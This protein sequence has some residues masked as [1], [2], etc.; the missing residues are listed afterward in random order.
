MNTGRTKAGRGKQAKKSADAF[1]PT[2]SC[3]ESGGTVTSG[4]G[5]G[6]NRNCF[7]TA[8]QYRPMLPKN[9]M[10]KFSQLIFPRRNSNM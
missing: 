6:G 1:N 7:P 4:S 8:G 9:G 2:F 3:K 5:S 10:L